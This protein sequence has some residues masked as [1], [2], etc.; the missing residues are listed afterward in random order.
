MSPPVYATLNIYGLLSTGQNAI[1]KA[2]QIDVDL[3]EAGEI[4]KDS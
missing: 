3:S 2:E 1:P 4:C